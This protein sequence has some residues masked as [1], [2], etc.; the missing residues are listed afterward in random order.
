MNALV[1][2][3]KLAKYYKTSCVAY[4]RNHMKIDRVPVIRFLPQEYQNTERYST[5][6]YGISVFA[7]TFVFGTVSVYRTP[8]IEST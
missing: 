3:F 8:L 6:G 1:L 7:N 4:L 2:H 5:F